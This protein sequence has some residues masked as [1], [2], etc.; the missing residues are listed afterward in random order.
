MTCAADHVRPDVLGVGTCGSDRLAL[1]RGR[2]VAECVGDARRRAELGEFEQCSEP[3]RSGVLNTT[4]S[5][6]RKLEP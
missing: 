6:S 2:V 1:D 4:F 3:D 5:L